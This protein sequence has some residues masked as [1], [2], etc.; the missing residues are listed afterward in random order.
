MRLEDSSFFYLF[1]ATQRSALGVDTHDHLTFPKL[2]PHSIGHPV[3]TT[4]VFIR[5]HV[6]IMDEWQTWCK[7]CGGVDVRTIRM[8]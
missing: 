4:R 8:N 2:S 6:P 7:A 3:D 1:E 5:E